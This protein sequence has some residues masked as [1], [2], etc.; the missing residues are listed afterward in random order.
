MSA[1][2][3]VRTDVQPSPVPP[4]R[5]LAAALWRAV[6]EAGVGHVSGVPG[7]YSLRLLEALEAT[8]GLLWAGCSTELGAAFVADG[9]ARAR[10]LGVVCTTYGVGEL[11]ALGA[12][13]GW[14]AEDVAVLH[15]VGAPASDR[16]RR[17]AAVHH[18]LA[19]GDGGHWLRVAAEAGAAVHV[20][21][22]DRPEA[23]G[24]ALTT[25]RRDRR[26]A[27]LVVPHD[28]VDL[29]V[30]SPSVVATG[31]LVAQEVRDRAAALVHRFVVAAPRATVV[32]GHL[33]HRRG[34]RD[35]VEELAALGT[36]LA[37]LPAGR[38]AVDDDDP[39][40]LGSYQGPLS[41]PGVREAV[42]SRSGRALLGGTLSDAATAGFAH[43]LSVG[44][45]LVLGRDALRWGDEEV[46]VP[47]EVATAALVAARRAV[48]AGGAAGTGGTVRARPARASCAA[49]PATDATAAVT[50]ARLWA[51]LEATLP[52][53]HRVV[54]DPGTATSGVLASHLPAGTR[55][56]SQTTWAAIGFALPAALGAA[57]AA[58]DE[59]VLA[60][61]G[62][63][64][65]RVTFQELGLVRSAG[66]RIVLVLVDNGGYT[67][68]RLLGDPSARHHDVVPWDWPALVRAVV[69]PDLVDVATPT[70]D[71]ELRAAL[72]AAFS[73]RDRAQVV[74]VRTDPLDAPP[75][76]HAVARALARS[77]SRGTAST[78]AAPE[79]GA[80]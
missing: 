6:A 14:A 37:V 34:L 26:P 55:L 24:A 75:A 40:L 30:P 4:S 5:P 70:T 62:D 36:P 49:A 2:D 19:D 54:V 3:D 79:G 76:L 46:R 42:E 63:G 43:D 69:G 25:W 52:P 17:G 7:D 8:P 71:G 61:V 58:P 67:I 73:A 16:L 59:R 72:A 68:E 29:P 74:V 38:T 53:A 77:R 10:G 33:V 1:R 20:V 11:S 31:A 64:A 32:L 44:E 78:V 66:A 48:A 21:A 47:I 18:S 23:L 60:V 50:Q 80:S 56:E 9:Q 45:T 57:L 13:A 22:P 65:A 51:A 28:L 12:A 39:A 15:V 41:A 27:V 35:A